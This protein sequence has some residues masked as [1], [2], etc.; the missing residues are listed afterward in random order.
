MVAQVIHVRTGF[1]VGEYICDV[2]GSL[3][4]VGISSA[5]TFDV[6]LQVRIRFGEIFRYGWTHS[7]PSSQHTSGWIPS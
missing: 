6:A 2:R 4:G 1:I 3:R 5:I 7:K